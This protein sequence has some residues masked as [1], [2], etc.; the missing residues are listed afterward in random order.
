MNFTEFF[1]DAEAWVGVG[2]VLFFGLLFVLKVP[3]AA[4]KSLDDRA[5]GIQAALDEALALR[6]EATVLLNSL[7]Q[8][9]ADTERQAAAML[10][11]ARARG[12]YDLLVEAEIGAYLD[13]VDRRFDLIVALDVLVCF[14]ELEQLVTRIAARLP[15]GGLFACSLETDNAEPET[16]DDADEPRAAGR[17]HER[18]GAGPRLIP[19]GRFRHSRPYF[20]AAAHAAF[21]LVDSRTVNLRLDAGRPVRGEILLLARR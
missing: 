9:R 7:R 2:L 16:G 12:S 8:Q 6:D 13:G 5:A 10:A 19:A 20:M 1:Q 17:G 15:S 18:L 14:G 21:Q 3:G 11:E 4:G